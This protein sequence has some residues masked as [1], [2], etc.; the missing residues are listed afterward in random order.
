MVLHLSED[1]G[2]GADQF[3]SGREVPVVSSGL[4]RGLP[5]ALGGIELRGVRWQLVHFQPLA[6][7][8]EP[9]PYRSILVVGGVVLNQ[10]GSTPPIAPCQLFQEGEV[11]GGVEDGV[12]P[13][14]ETGVPQFDGSQDLYALAFSCD[15]HFGRVADAAPGG[16]QRGVLSKT[17][18]IGENQRPALGSGFFLRLG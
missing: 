3:R 5:E 9:I 1:P 12:L 7:G 6:I 18:F 15:R 11:G 14:M 16:M 13:V 17:G 2:Q 8:A 4:A 10:N